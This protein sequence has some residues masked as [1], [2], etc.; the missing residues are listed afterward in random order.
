MLDFKR[1][2]WS[3][4]EGRRNIKSIE[5]YWSEQRAGLFSESHKEPTTNTFQQNIFIVGVDVCLLLL[6]GRGVHPWILQSAITSLSPSLCKTTCKD[7]TPTQNPALP[8]N[9]IL[10]CV[11]VH[12]PPHPHTHTTLYRNTPISAHS[13]YI[14][15]TTSIKNPI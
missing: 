8:S 14:P 1:P 5:I 7:R 11:C 12:I 15:S 3:K 2:A 9:L 6:W 13:H 10:L 4:I